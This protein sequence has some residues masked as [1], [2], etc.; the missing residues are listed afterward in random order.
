MIGMGAIV[1]DGSKIARGSL[2]AA[3][4]LVTQGLIVPPGSLVMGT[5]GKIVKTLSEEEQGRMLRSV[6]NYLTLVSDYLDASAYPD[7]KKVKGFLG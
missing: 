3:G 6:T 4:S 5:P 7:A 1:M 2:I